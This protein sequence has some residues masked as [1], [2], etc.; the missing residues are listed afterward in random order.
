MDIRCDEQCC[1]PN[2]PGITHGHEGN[3]SWSAWLPAV[4][5]Y[6]D[7]KAGSELNKDYR[8]V[9]VEED[10]TETLIKI[11]HPTDTPERA[12]MMKTLAEWNY[13]TCALCHLVRMDME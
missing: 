12:K 9:Y 3:A 10:G 2:T 8:A 4:N 1:V 6:Y 11:F 5:L 13:G 7:D